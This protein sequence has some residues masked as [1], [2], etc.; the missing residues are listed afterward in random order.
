MPVRIILLENQPDPVAALGKAEEWYEHQGEY[1]PVV[2]NWNVVRGLDG[3]GLGAAMLGTLAPYVLGTANGR[4]LIASGSWENPAV[5]LTLGVGRCRMLRRA[6]LAHGL[7][8]IKEPLKLDD[9]HPAL[10]HARRVIDNLGKCQPLTAPGSGSWNPGQV[11][12][13][14]GDKPNSAMHGTLKHRLPFFSMHGGGCSLWLSLYLEE[15]E[16]PEQQ[17]YWIN[18]SD[19]KGT[20]TPSDFVRALNPL[21][22]VALGA[23]AA[24]W[25]KTNSLIHSTVHHPSYVMRNPGML[26]GYPLAKVLHRYL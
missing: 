8:I 20:P 26:V 17:L 25:C 10:D 19:W 12:L 6:A 1:L 4:P 11:V 13:M 24:S 9:I 2:K 14:V 7:A 23:Q 15:H 5:A 21:G 22:V 16:V 3:R 18:S